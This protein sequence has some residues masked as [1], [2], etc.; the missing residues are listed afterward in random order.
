MSLPLPVGLIAAI[1]SP[2]AR[3]VRLRLRLRLLRLLL[4]EARGSGGGAALVAAAGAAEPLML[5]WR[6]AEA[7]GRGC[8]CCWVLLNFCSCCL[9]S[10]SAHSRYRSLADAHIYTYMYICMEVGIV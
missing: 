5:N 7:G 2:S 9:Y 3:R 1:A 6:G 8:T 4:R 10:A